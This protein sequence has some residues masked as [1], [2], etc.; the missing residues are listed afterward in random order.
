MLFRKAGQRRFLQSPRLAPVYSSGDPGSCAIAH[1]TNP[2]GRRFLGPGRCAPLRKQK[3][4]L[5]GN[6][7][8]KCATCHV[9][10]LYSEPGHNL[11]AP[12]EIGID[13]FQADRSPTHMYRAAP[14]AGLWTHQKGGFFHGGRFAALLDVVNHYGVEFNLNLSDANKTDLVE[15]L[16]GI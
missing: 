8:A 15:Y 7:P 14:L 9:P 2:C 3:V 11:H 1:E 5:H 16:K 12:S 13:A 10:P 6:G 4:C